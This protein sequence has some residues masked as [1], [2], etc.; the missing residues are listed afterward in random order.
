VDRKSSLVVAALLLAALAVALIATGARGGGTGALTG[1]GSDRPEPRNPEPTPHHFPTEAT[2]GVPRGVTPTEPALDGDGNLTVTEDG[3]VVDAVDV[4]GCIDVRAVGVR[5]RDSRAQCI[6]TS[7]SPRAQKPANPRLVVED[8]EVDC[9]TGRGGTG[10]DTGILS[11]NITVR[12]TEIRG[13]E[14]GLEMDRDFTL[15]DSLVHELV[16][17]ARPSCAEPDRHTDGIQSADG[18]NLTIRRNTILAFTPPCRPRDGGTCNGTAAV[19]INDDPG[20]NRV[21][22]GTVIEDNLLGGGAYTLY[23]PRAKTSDYRIVG[24]HF[25]TRY[26]EKVGAYGPSTGC[27]DEEASGNV[28]LESGTPVRLG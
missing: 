16:H 19:N 15:E 13:C 4:P 3:A 5:I 12:R 7:G 23:C 24:N 18:S 21:I 1:T 25:T 14:N 22:A 6:T 11:R 26:S 10:G 9:R 2:T 8:S 17:C 20:Y 28:H 27:G